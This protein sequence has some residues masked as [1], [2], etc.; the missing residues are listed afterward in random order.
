MSAYS[1]ALSD[2]QILCFFKHGQQTEKP[3]AHEPELVEMVILRLSSHYAPHG[4][5][6]DRFRNEVSRLRP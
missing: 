4:L 3:P 1:C 2:T 5:A 6:N